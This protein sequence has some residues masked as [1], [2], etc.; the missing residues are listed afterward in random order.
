MS[1]GQGQSGDS[2]NNQPDRAPC[3]KRG[4]HRFDPQSGLSLLFPQMD[5]SGRLADSSPCN[6]PRYLQISSKTTRYFTIHTTH[7]EMVDELK[8]SILAKFSG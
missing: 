8:H 3:M 1:K 5:Y 6:L 4:S 7:I 2:S